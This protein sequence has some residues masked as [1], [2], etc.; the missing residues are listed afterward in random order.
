MVQ[1]RDPGSSKSASKLSSV[2]LTITNR[3]TTTAMSVAVVV[4]GKRNVIED[5]HSYFIA[6]RQVSLPVDFRYFAT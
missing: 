2:L 3:P 1:T 4:T 5:P 6:I